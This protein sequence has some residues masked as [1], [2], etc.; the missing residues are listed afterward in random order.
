MKVEMQEKPQTSTEGTINHQ[1][2]KTNVLCIFVYLSGCCFIVLLHCLLVCDFLHFYSPVL[3]MLFCFAV[4]VLSC[5]SHLNVL[6]RFFIVFYSY[7][8][9]SFLFDTEYSMTALPG[10]FFRVR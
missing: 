4:S 9:D 2:M 8:C 5:I 3:Y 1:D 6:Y 7:S 10:S